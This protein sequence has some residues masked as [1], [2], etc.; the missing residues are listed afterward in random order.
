MALTVMSRFLFCNQASRNQTLTE[1]IVMSN[2][3]SGPNLLSKPLQPLRSSFRA[4]ID[5]S[6]IE[7][8]W[9]EHSGC[10]APNALGKPK[11]FRFQRFR[12]PLHV[13]YHALIKIKGPS[14]SLKAIQP[15][16]LF[17]SATSMH[18]HRGT[19]WKFTPVLQKD[20]IAI[21]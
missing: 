21:N 9:S 7:T 10:S 17:F 11:T 6:A 13:L 19:R 5:V 3:L 8:S 12:I 4:G 20:M 1:M 14:H 16:P 15:N 18:N 2:F